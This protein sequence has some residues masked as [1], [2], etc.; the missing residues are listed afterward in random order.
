MKIKRF[1]SNDMRNVI[2]KV[3]EELG[4]DAVILSNNRVNGGVEIIAAV[5]YDASLLESQTE[6]DAATEYV[7]SEPAATPRAATQQQV[8]RALASDRTEAARANNISSSSRQPVVNKYMDDIPEQ[9]AE[10]SNHNHLTGEEIRSRLKRD[11]HKRGIFNFQQEAEN[12][13]QSSIRDKAK[14]SLVANHERDEQQAAEA[15]RPKAKD[16]FESTLDKVNKFNELQ[17]ES[18][19][20]EDVRPER[21]KA[22]SPVT[23]KHPPAP[24]SGFRFTVLDEEQE[25]DDDTPAKVALPTTP[26]PKVS[27]ELFDTAGLEADIPKAGTSSKKTGD[28]VWSQE[29]TLVDMRNEIK[30]LRDLLQQQLTG[31]AW[32]EVARKN[33]VKAKL[34]RKLLEMNLS[35]LI[36]QKIAQA[37]PNSLEYD[38]AWPHALALMANHLPVCKE[39]ISQ[40][41]GVVALLGPT[42]VGKTTTIAKLAARY[43]FRHGNDKVAL[44][45][46]DSFR[47]GAHEQLRTYGRIL[48]IP[49]KV[50]KSR[51]ELVD[52]LSSLSDRKLV[53]IDTAGVSHRD[54]K[55]KEQLDLL[56]GCVP[57]LKMYL[58]LSATTH[59][60]GLEEAVESFRGAKVNAC[61][62]TKMD[63][64]TSMGGVLSIAMRYKL[65][66]AYISNGQ[67]VPEDLHPARAHTLVSRAVALA[68]QQQQKSPLQ[69]EEIE[70]ALS[71]T[72]SN[73][74]I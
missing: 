31:L 48:N 47:V 39:D 53:L 43:T 71:G 10:L 24:T 19:L 22:P 21:N 74:G 28:S 57:N 32:G 13:P 26:K 50:A 33:P 63:E 41:G 3:R 4:P 69:P 1:F 38:S 6:K 16:D 49:V 45:T 73:V 7:S 15:L 9:D 30:T 65:P 51:A 68:D 59:R 66:I 64:T 14:F 52:V 12:A 35:P 17:G 25:L 11:Q 72:L 23:A 54:P 18:A 62:F 37:L 42:G 20:I 27:E 2:R 8:E 5:D 70:L 40:H 56:D 60:S 55:L 58:V 44:V 67:K 46:T 36:T 29:P 61:V 34:I